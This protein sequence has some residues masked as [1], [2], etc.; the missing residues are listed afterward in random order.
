MNQYE[1]LTTLN[2]TYKFA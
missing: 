1:H 2:K